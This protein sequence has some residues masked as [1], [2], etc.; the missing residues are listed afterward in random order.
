[1]Q[2]FSA[3]DPKLMMHINTHT[4]TCSFA[5][6]LTRRTYLTCHHITGFIVLFLNLPSFLEA[7]KYMFVLSP[8][9]YVSISSHDVSSLSLH[10]LFPS[11]SSYTNNN[12]KALTTTTTTS[13]CR[14]RM[15]RRE[16]RL[17][18]PRHRIHKSCHTHTHTGQDSRRRQITN[19]IESRMELTLIEM[20]RC[21]DPIAQLS[22]SCGEAGSE[23]T[24]RFGKMFAVAR[25]RLFDDKSKQRQ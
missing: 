22:I 10:F 3:C 17:P 7:G 25:Q 2:C 9:P 8:S 20:L 12:I 18:P 6:S 13:N 4:H 23:L 15:R 14:D 16:K 24:L 5:F 19:V 11:I 1:M 21:S